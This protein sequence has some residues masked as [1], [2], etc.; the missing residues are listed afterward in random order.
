MRRLSLCLLGLAVA[1]LTAAGLGTAARFGVF[2]SRTA[3]VGVSE[4]DPEAVGEGSGMP[5]PAGLCPPP[6]EPSGASGSD[7]TV[8]GPCAFHQVG[9]V[10]CRTAGDDFYLLLHRSL[11]EG[12]TLDLYLDV[13]YYA[14]PGTYRE[15][16]VL[17]LIQDKTTIY[18]WS[19]FRSVATV[20]PR[21]AAVQM[22]RTELL[23]EAGR[24]GDGTEVVV[25]RLGCGA[26]SAG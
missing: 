5:L 13:E 25:G 8:D 26:P 3:P 17:L 4:L 20:E 18:T 14:G 9:R 6:P 19:N 23:P 7:F 15:T 16:Q 10:Y 21:G 22:P 1:A 2:Q 12:R 11:P 24:G